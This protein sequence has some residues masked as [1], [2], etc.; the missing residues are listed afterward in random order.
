MQTNRITGL[1]AAPFTALNKDASLNLHAIEKQAEHLVRNGVSGAFVCG[2]TGESASLTVQERMQV[3]ERWSSVLH[4][5]LTLMVHVG[6]NCLD[7]SR[8]L[9]RHAQK[10]GADAVS[11]IAPSFFKPESVDDL[12]CFCRD[13][14]HAAPELPFYYYHMPA[15]TGVR[16]QMFDFTARA[17]EAIRSFGGVKFTNEDLMDYRRTLLL[18][19]GRADVLWGRD[20]VLLSA[21]AMG[22]RGA[23]GSTYNYAA[24]IYH[25]VIR[26][27]KNGDM[28]GAQAAQTLAIEFIARMSQCGG[29][30]AG[31]AIMEMIGIDCG[32][33]RSPLH[34]LAPAQRQAFRAS[35]EK[36]GFFDAVATSR[37]DAG[38]L[39]AAEL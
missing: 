8:L 1:V 34:N 12:V 32:P 27:Y 3:A 15:M 25:D 37:A 11:C 2:T 39:A 7:D 23:V 24:P 6:S 36:I 35:L 16:F 5:R 38:A 28:P 26:C 30:P 22:A 9:A 21:L 31:K 33:V 20:E 10:I 17:F 14:A 4:H 29:L 18:V 13:I 19:D